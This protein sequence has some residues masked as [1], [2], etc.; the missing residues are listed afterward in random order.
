MT[1]SNILGYV[2]VPDPGSAAGHHV[3]AARGVN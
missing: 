3:C 1:K 2:A